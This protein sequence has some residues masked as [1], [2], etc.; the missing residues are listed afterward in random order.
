MTSI[1]DTISRLPDSYN[2]DSTSNNYKLLSIFANE[3]DDIADTIAD[4]KSAH[5]IDSATGMS[6]DY[7]GVMLQTFRET[8]ETDAHYRVRLKT[9][10]AR[11]GSSGTIQDILDIVAAMLSVETNRIE[12]IEDFVG[13]YANFDVWVWL[14]DLTDAGITASELNDLLDVVK[15]AGISVAA[16]A[17]GTFTARGALDANDSI[18]GYDDIAHTNPNGGTY[19]G[20]IA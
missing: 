19:S 2:R 17:Y 11:Y 20:I 12:V 5:F 14:Q 18:L 13:V 8:A 1:D 10:W 4:I 16:H 15:G 3:H 6:L 7:F 9:M